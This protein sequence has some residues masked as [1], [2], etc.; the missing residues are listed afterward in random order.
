M[1]FIIQLQSGLQTHATIIPLCGSALYS[2]SRRTYT[3]RS[4][5]AAG[6]TA[7]ENHDQWTT[8]KSQANHRRTIQFAHPTL[9]NGKQSPMADNN[10]NVR[11][12]PEGVKQHNEELEQ[13]HDRP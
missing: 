3:H 7:I 11:D 1:A 5:A 9:S 6:E 4:P 10:G 8:D 2:L 12:I 13:R